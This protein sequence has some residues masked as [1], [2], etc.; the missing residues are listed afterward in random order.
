MKKNLLFILSI[1]C[2]GAMTSCSILEDLGITKPYEI[3][4]Y[5]SHEEVS[6]DTFCEL[7]GEELN[8]VYED[9]F[10]SNVRAEDFIL[11]SGEGESIKSTVKYEDTSCK[12]NIEAESITKQEISYDDDTEN[13]KI[14]SKTKEVNN[15]AI[16]KQET[17]SEIEAYMMNK[18]D[19]MITAIKDLKAYVFQENTSVEE[20]MELLMTQ[21]FWNIV[22]TIDNEIPAS[23]S[24]YEMQYYVEDNTFTVVG[25]EYESSGSSYDNYLIETTV[26]GVWQIVIDD[27][28]ISYVCET[29][30]EEN[31]ENNDSDANQN[32]E[33]SSY[34]YISL[35]FADQ[36]IKDINYTKYAE[37]EDIDFDY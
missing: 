24:A 26:K 17:S 11:K 12:V 10:A 31:V 5:K 37:V 6:Y 23:S 2:L 22:Q 27:D 15:A 19:G 34:K 18:G 7:I 14:Y 8:E 28:Y 30:A 36:K 32:S 29:E 4:S 25:E 3:K 21:G 13:A 33:I 9:R 16:A 1:A 35:E 20:G